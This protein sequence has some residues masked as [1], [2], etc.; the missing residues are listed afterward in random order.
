MIVDPELLKLLCCPETHQ[1]LRL[2]DPELVEK[3]NEQVHLG[4]LRNRSGRQV[5]RKL[6][7]AL[8]RADGKFLYPI[9]ENIPVMLADEAIPLDPQ[10][11]S[12]DSKT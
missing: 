2:G 10:F 7:G 4:V 9:C 1:D 6:D 5:E 8:I 12:R 3:L 11:Q